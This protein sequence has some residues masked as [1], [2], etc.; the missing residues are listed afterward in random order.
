MSVYG[1][2]EIYLL[3]DAGQHEQMSSQMKK[4]TEKAEG[5][6]RRRKMVKS[7]GL[8]KLKGSRLKYPHL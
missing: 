7:R 3:C 4:S 5:V 1:Y 2:S 8:S 6:E